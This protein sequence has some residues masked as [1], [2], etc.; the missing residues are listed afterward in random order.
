LEFRDVSIFRQDANELAKKVTADIVYIDPPYNSR[1]YSRFYHLLETLVKWDKKELF[2]TAL[3]PVT[4]NMSAYCTVKAPQVFSEL[5]DDLDAKYIV[6]SYNNTYNPKSHSS[7]NKIQL[8]EIQKTL[9]SKGSTQIFQ[10]DH[11]FFN[12]GKTDFANHQEL[13][14]ITKV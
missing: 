10:K 5:I 14:F 8:E 1:Q 7:K 9:E 11:K 6:V 13:L 4:E 2:G 3:K 12:S